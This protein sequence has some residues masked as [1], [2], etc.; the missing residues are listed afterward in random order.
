MFGDSATPTYDRPYH[1]WLPVANEQVLPNGSAYAYTRFG[2]QGDLTNEIH[3]VDVATAVDTM[4]YDQGP[5]VALDYE[6][7]GLYVTSFLSGGGRPSGLWL[8]DPT[9]RSL[10][11]FPAAQGPTWAQVAGGV[12]WSY[13][14]DGGSKF[15]GLDLA[16]GVVTVWLDVSN[17]VQ[18]YDDGYKVVVPIGFDSSFHP[19][20]EV[21]VLPADH[22]SELWLLTGPG[23]ATRLSDPPDIYATVNSPGVTDPYG[24]W[25]GAKNG[26]YLFTNSGAQRV[27]DAPPAVDSYAHYTVAG[28]CL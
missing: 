9:T 5:Y 2:E 12:A 19:L 25:L 7:E 21:T 22:A 13:V 14:S 8:L 15:V 20:V 23:H 6:P 4:I 26:V 11:A 27:A 10:K 1:R 24:V 3:V 16:T 18:P 17:N 28:S